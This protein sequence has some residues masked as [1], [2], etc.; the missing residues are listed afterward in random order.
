MTDTQPSSK[1]AINLKDITIKSASGVALY[2]LVDKTLRGSA[3]YWEYVNVGIAGGA[4]LLIV[5]PMLQN[6]M[7]GKDLLNG[8]SFNGA[9]IKHVAVDGALS[10]GI[11]W[12]LKTLI[13]GYTLDDS[14]LYKY[15]AVIC[16]IIGADMVAPMVLAHL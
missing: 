12:A 16:S 7:D 14:L 13:F 15:V 11:Y 8:I 1:P 5:A 2:W 4:G 6:M 10:A 9:M 3:D